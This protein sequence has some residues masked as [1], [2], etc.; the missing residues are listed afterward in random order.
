MFKNVIA[1]KPS[2]SLENGITYNPELGG[3]DY[4]I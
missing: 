4:I 2:K 3:P 1:K